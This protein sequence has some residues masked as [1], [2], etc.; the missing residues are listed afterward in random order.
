MKTQKNLTDRY[1][2]LVETFITA[3]E[4]GKSGSQLEDIRSEIRNISLQ[5]GVSFSVEN[6]TQEQILRTGELKTKLSNEKDTTV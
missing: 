2:Q 1:I 3:L 4:S 6:A 5:L